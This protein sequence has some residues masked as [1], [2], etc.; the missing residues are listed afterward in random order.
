VGFSTRYWLVGDHEP[1]VAYLARAAWDPSATPEA[2]YRDQVRAACG[3]AAVEDMLAVFREVEAATIALEGHGLGLTFPVPNMLLQHWRPAPFPPELAE[4]RRTYERA[5]GAARRALAKAALVGRPYVDYWVG[6]LEFGIGYLDTIEEIR[7][8][9]HAEA[10]KK[11]EETARRAEAALTTFRRALEAY[12]RVARDQSDRGTLATLAEF[13]YRPL[14]D[15]ATKL[16][17]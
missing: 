14:R 5:L 3:P 4:D 13:A 12:A 9:A 10:D 6:R 8:A 11:P 17:G 2:V 16:K 1:C 15:K 7:L